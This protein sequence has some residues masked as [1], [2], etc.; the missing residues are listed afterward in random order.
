[1][2][3]EIVLA[4]F[5]YLVL[6]LS[7]SIHDAA[8]AWTASRLGDPTAR[9]L[10]R[11]SL[12]PLRHYDLW[13]TV[14]WPLL[15]VYQSPLIIGWGRDVPVTTGNLRKHSQVNLVH[16]SGPAAQLAAA[17]LC[18]ILLVIVKHAVPG[19]AGIITVIA[20]LYALRAPV[21][22][23]GALPPLF[24]LLLLLYLGI[25]VNVLLAV[26]NLIPL[27]TLDGGKI[28]RYYLPYNAARTYDEYASWITIGF[29]LLTW[30]F[31]II[32]W[33]FAPVLAVYQGLLNAL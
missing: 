8:E 2:S 14:I 5:E 29:F 31:N 30:R 7:I 25:V 24:P 9:M 33:L 10:G 15:F 27:P 28:L 16:L 6:V 17:A 21:I 11:I 26:F 13:G 18:L 3:L 23:P 32:V 19:A 4:L 22:A 20:P 1:M 12:N